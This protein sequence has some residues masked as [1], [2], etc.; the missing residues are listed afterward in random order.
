MGQ[1]TM[2]KVLPR[3]DKLYVL[4]RKGG[5]RLTGIEAGDGKVL[6][7]ELCKRLIFDYTNKWYVPKIK[8]VQEN[9]THEIFWKIEIQIDQRIPAQ[10]RLSVNE[11]K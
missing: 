4:R 3:D 9:G 7:W 8:F 6:Y 2:L 5:R 10:R 11:T 1:K